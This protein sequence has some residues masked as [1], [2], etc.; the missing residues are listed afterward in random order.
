MEPLD[1]YYLK[2]GIL[3]LKSKWPRRI[4]LLIATSF[5]AVSLTF[6]N[7]TA[8]SS[9]KTYSD[10]KSEY[11]NYIVDNNPKV[12]K[13]DARNITI[14]TL[15]WAKQFNLDEKLMLAVASVESNFNKYAISTSGAYGVMQVIPVWHKDKILQARETIGNPEIFN[16]NTNIYLGAWVL[17]DCMNKVNNNLSK[18]LLCYSGQ[19]PGYDK[20]VLAEYGNLKKL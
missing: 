10:W 12:S 19:T 2:E 4:K 1:N 18:A 3:F 5:I 7:D 20:K 11:V 6:V 8:Y 14:A 17:S 13:N 16:I 15:R 9:Y